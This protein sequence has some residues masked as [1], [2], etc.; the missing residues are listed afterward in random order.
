M[1]AALAYFAFPGNLALAAQV[2]IAG[3]FALSLDVLLGYTGIASLGHAAFFGFGGYT[4]ALL[5]ASGHGEPI[6]GLIAAG[7]VA[8]IIGFICGLFVARLTGIALLTVTLGIG[9][10]VYEIANRARGITG[11]VDGIQGITTAPVFGVFSFDLYGHTAYVFT[12]VVVFLVYLAARHLVNSPFGLELTGIRENIRRMPALG[13][14]VRRR[15][16]AAFTVSAAIAGIAGGLLTEVTQSCALN[17]VSFDRS[18]AV[19]IMVVLG[20]SGSLIGAFIGAAV[21][22]VAQDRLSSL[23]PVY[24][25]FWVGLM[26]VVVVLAARGG[27]VGLFEAASRRLRKRG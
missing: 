11:G 22:I 7:V 10:L 18:V 5:S 27:I 21:F 1:L 20:G 16:V 26:L 25:N 6:S 12:Y 8:A 23:D 9:L 13:V 24:W 4:V 3:L 19:L 17:V 14:S 2:L 15:Y